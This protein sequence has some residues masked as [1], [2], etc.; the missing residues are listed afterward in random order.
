MRACY[1]IVGTEE[2]GFS[3]INRYLYSLYI[4]MN[5][6]K[7]TTDRYR[8]ASVHDLDGYV[9]HFCYRRLKAF[10]TLLKV[11]VEHKD[12]LSSACILRMLGD[13]VAVFNLIYLE[14]DI[15]HL[16]LRH[17]LY[18]IDG[19]EQSLKVLPDNNNYN[20]GAMPDEELNILNQGIRYNRE[21]R[22]RFIHEAQQILDASPLQKKDKEAFD[23]IVEDRNWKFKEFKSYKKKGAN[24]YKWA[25]LYEKIGRCEGFDVLSFLSQFVHS[26]SMSN[27]VMEMNQENCDGV[28]I[29]G[30]ALL[31]KL[32]ECTLEFFCN[33]FLY[34]MDGFYVPEIRDK[35]LKCYDDAHR[36]SIE[37]WN[38]IVKSSI[39]HAYGN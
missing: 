37:Q 11:V 22:Q 25:E 39:N 6:V 26:L 17:A 10:D 38:E 16:W 1:H 24:Q 14:S 7:R 5:T 8:N 15:N 21:L 18:V 3:T 20:R 36:P 2:F 13:S 28:L 9:A 34:I 32:N 31:K 27:L 19:C 33:D 12:Y 30:S 23:K 4:Y 29:E 35:I